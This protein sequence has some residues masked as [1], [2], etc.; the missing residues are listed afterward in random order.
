[1]PSSF[2]WHWQL[3]ELW[4]KKI[5]F[6]EKSREMSESGEEWKIGEIYTVCPISLVNNKFSWQLPRLD[7]LAV[8]TR[9]RD[10]LHFATFN[11][12]TLHI[13]AEEMDH[14]T[15]LAALCLCKTGRS[16]F[17]SMY[18]GGDCVVIFNLQP[19]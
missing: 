3:D 12:N 18:N 4:R 15:Y 8:S 5:P 6:P 13:V 19:M 10:D 2:I 17:G 1:M 9:V 7:W 14:V 11:S 16:A